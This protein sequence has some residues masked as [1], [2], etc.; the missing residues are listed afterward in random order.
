MRNLHTLLAVENFKLSE[1][2]FRRIP[3]LEELHLRY[4]FQGSSNLEYCQYNLG[5]FH[6]LES[7]VKFLWYIKLASFRD[8]LDIP[9][10]AQG[11]VVRKLESP[12]ERS[13]DDWSVA[14]SR[15]AHVD[16]YRFGQRRGVEPYRGGIPSIE[17]IDNQPLLRL[18]S[19]ECGEVSLSGFGD[20]YA[21]ICI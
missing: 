18:G 8:T 17:I 6:R 10:F 14:T 19:L 9:G 1:E 11:V 12:L 16:R 21:Q 20:S 5:H 13:I 4:N 2:V 7:E 3:N 15:S